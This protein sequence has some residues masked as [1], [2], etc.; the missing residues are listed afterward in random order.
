M[1]VKSVVKFRFW[2]EGI[3]VREANAKMKVPRKPYVATIN[4][5]YVTNGKTPT[6]PAV[7]TKESAISMN[8]I[9]LA[10]SKLT[11]LH[12]WR[13]GQPY[14]GVAGIDFICAICCLALSIIC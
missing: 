3:P 9:T 6:T 8:A 4:K 2:G 11:L 10:M 12:S 7:G 13:N 5:K 1:A 14:L